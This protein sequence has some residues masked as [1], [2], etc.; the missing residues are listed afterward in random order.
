MSFGIGSGVALA[1]EKGYPP[2][3]PCQYQRM[4][5]WRYELLVGGRGVYLPQTLLDPIPHPVSRVDW[6]H[7]WGQ[8]EP[9]LVLVYPPHFPA[10]HLSL[11]L[12]LPR[13]QLSS[14]EEAYPQLN[15][16][17]YSH[18]GLLVHDHLEHLQQPP[19]HPNEIPHLLAPRPHL[20]PHHHLHPH[21]RPLP[22]LRRQ[23]GLKP[24]YGVVEVVVVAWG[25]V[26]LV[27]ALVEVQVGGGGGEGEGGV[28]GVDG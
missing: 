19:L 24:V 4:P 22:Q 17:E 1:G 5:R 9:V 20:Q 12:F 15:R 3:S 18:L 11:L 16:G 14:R 7:A 28:A 25:V 6:L 23:R 21:H 26:N 8:P 13:R 2:S 27:V 10:E